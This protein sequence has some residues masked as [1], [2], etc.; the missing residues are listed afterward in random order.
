MEAPATSNT[1][2]QMDTGDA[3]ESILDYICWTENFTILCNAIQQAGLTFLGGIT[4]DADTSI[5][6][7]FAT[8]N[9]GMEDAGLTLDTI[10][11]MDTTKLINILKNH[12]L[13]GEKKAEELI[14]D[15]SYTTISP[16]NPLIPSTS[17]SVDIQCIE[18]M[19]IK[20]KT[21]SGPNNTF[22]NRPTILS[23]DNIVLCNGIVQPIDHAIR[24]NYD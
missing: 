12:I 22:L 17:S 13:T 19:G 23:P 5:I 6:T 8:T 2:G 3:P 20:T 14:C 18:I 10:E 7:L 16:S 9:E 21:V 1:C 4:T 15:E 11:T 24:K